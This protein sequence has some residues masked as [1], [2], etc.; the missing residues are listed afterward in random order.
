MRPPGHSDTS[1]SRRPRRMLAS[2]GRF[3]SWRVTA[4]DAARRC[5]PAGGASRHPAYT[6]DMA[7]PEPTGLTARQRQI[8][9]L[10]VE[11][12]VATGQPVGSKHLVESARMDVSPSTVRAELAELEAMGLLTHPHTSAGRVPTDRG[13]RAHVDRLLAR[14]EPRPRPLALDLRA[15]HEVEVALQE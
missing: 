7:T 6:E 12:Y 10:V 15:R 9:R 1:C 8:L 13:Y 5:S 11:E 4:A 14:L 2:P 3:E